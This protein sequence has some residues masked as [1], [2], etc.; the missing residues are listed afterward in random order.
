[1]VEERHSEEQSLHEAW[2]LAGQLADDPTAIDQAQASH[3][4]AN[5]AHEDGAEGGEG[6]SDVETDDD[7]MDRISSSPSIDDGG[8]TL[9]SSPPAPTPAHP[10][11]DSTGRLQVAVPARSRSMSP[12]STI[13]PTREH[14]NSSSVSPPSAASSTADTVGSSPFVQTPLHLPLRRLGGHREASPL[15]RAMD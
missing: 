11:A 9:P 15:S 5:G 3:P 8:S 12:A 13:T 10:H 4:H 2:N 7:M 1:M 14:F 6:E